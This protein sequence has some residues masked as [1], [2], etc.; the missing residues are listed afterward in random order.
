MVKLSLIRDGN[1]EILDVRQ[2]ES[3]LLPRPTPENKTFLGWSL[4]DGLDYGFMNIAPDADTTLYAVC[5]DGPAY[6]LDSHFRGAPEDNRD[7][8]CQFRRYIVDVYLE[9]AVASCGEFKLENVNY[10][11][12]YLGNVPVGD[13]GVTVDH[14]TNQRGGAYNGEAFFTT[15][16]MTVK[17]QSDKPVDASKTRQKIATLMLCFGKW[18]MSYREIERRT[19]DEIIIPAK[20]HTALADGKAAL[21]SANFYNGAVIEDNITYKNPAMLTVKSENELPDIELGE[22]LSRFAVMSD[23]HIG[24]RYGWSDYN[25]LYGVFESLEKIHKK[26]LLDFVLELGDNIDDGYAATYKAD[27]ETYLDVIKKLTICDPVAPIDNRENGKIPH[28]ELQ[29]NHDTS[30]DTRFFRKKLWYNQNGNGKKVA[31][32]AFFTKYGGYPAVNSA[33]A[34]SGDSYKSYGIITDDMVEFVEEAIAE[35]K[36][37]GARHIVLCNHFGIAQELTAPILPESGLG[38]IE[39]L[40]KKHNIKLYLNGHE[41]NK[42][43]TLRKYNELYDYDAAMTRDKYAV[44]EIYENFAKVTIYNTSDNS[45]GR[46]DLIDLR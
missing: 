31:F 15:S 26:S 28:Y 37:K 41:H 42:D 45:V 1:V 43:Y 18:G 10:I 9:N 6:V 33:I 7:E 40:C 44:F 35:A 24:K 17:W 20:D 3:I 22:C 34:K 39:N 12:Y 8:R 29:G 5:T 2:G 36:E 11:L 16:D 46:I 21:V 14:T 38:K 32:V 19:G 27:Y 25:W 30:F 4:Y 13:I 23:S